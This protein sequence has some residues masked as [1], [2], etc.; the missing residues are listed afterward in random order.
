MKQTI[1]A[2]K[3]HFRTGISVPSFSQDADPK[4]ERVTKPTEKSWAF[5]PWEGGAC[6]LLCSRGLAVG[7]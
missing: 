3:S 4:L 7:L 6:R 2:V 1:Q 5:F